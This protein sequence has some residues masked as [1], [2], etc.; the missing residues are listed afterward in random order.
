MSPTFLG[1]A[2]E[3][4][5]ACGGVGAA[6]DF[7]LGKAGQKRLKGRVENFWLILSDVKLN[8]FGRAEACFA[9]GVIDRLFGARLLSIRRLA[10]S[11]GMVSLLI[12]VFMLASISSRSTPIGGP[13]EDDIIE[14]CM[15]GFFFALSFTATRMLSIVLRELSGRKPARNV[16][17]Y[18]LFLVVQYVLLLHW[19]I[20]SSN[21]SGLL[22]LEFSQVLDQWTSSR[23]VKAIY[24]NE[25]LN[26]LRIQLY[27]EP[28]ILLLSLL[29]LRSYL[30]SGMLRQLMFVVSLPRAQDAG[31]P[32]VEFF[33]NAIL[34]TIA[35]GMRLVLSLVFSVSFVL[36]PLQAFTLTV[37]ERLIENDQPACTLLFGGLAAAAKAGEWITRH[38]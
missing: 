14:I 9:L 37:V 36:R 32:H 5:A 34:G 11:A 13:R 28:R 26:E 22:A 18:F 30:P 20:V 33:L 16:L 17:I 7:W 24:W 27:Y 31:W 19:T 15:I 12:S 4:V 1:D 25:F 35:N 2:L 21:L 38:L 6:F 23:S 3:T 29:D 10:C 8:T